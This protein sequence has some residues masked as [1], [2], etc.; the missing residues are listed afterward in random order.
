MLLQKRSFLGK[1]PSQMGPLGKRAT[2]KV[3]CTNMGFHLYSKLVLLSNC[4]TLVKLLNIS[5]TSFTI[6]RM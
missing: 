2:S 6:Y 1:Q 3:K 5:Q 4:L